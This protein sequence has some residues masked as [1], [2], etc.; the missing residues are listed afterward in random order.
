MPWRVRGPSHISRAPHTMAGGTYTTRDIRHLWSA[1]RSC[2]GSHFSRR[3][4][5]AWRSDDW[6]TAQRCV[7]ALSG[8]CG[9]LCGRRCVAKLRCVSFAPTR[10]VIVTALSGAP[11]G[12][13]PSRSVMS[14][15]SR[16]LSSFSQLSAASPYPLPPVESRLH[17]PYGI[18]T[19]PRPPIR[20]AKVLMGYVSLP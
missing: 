7:D 19:D 6:S 9:A 14:D 18:H 1:L 20:V 10:S 13:P 5:G 16:I 8:M 11:P 12:C 2:A 4:R 15:A 17:S 3:E